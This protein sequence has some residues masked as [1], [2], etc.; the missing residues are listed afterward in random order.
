MRILH[1]ITVSESGGAQSVVISLAN[2]AV[3]AGHEAAVMSDPG[4][5]LWDALDARV[6]RFPCPAFVKPI[7]PKDD[8]FAYLAFRKRRR[9]YRPDIVHLHSSKPGLF[10]RLF[11]G[12]YRRHTVYTVHGFDTIRRG[13]RVFLPL[14][15]LFSRACGAVVA[16]SGHDRDALAAE[17]IV[18]RVSVIQNGVPDCRALAPP[19]GPALAALREARESGRFVALCVARLAPPKRFDLYAEA[20]ARLSDAKAAFFWVGNKAQPEGVVVP[21]NL[22]LLGDV[23][24]A[25]ALMGLCDAVVLLSDY[26]GLPMSV[27]EA[28]AWAK[29]VVASAVGG[30]PEALADG[31]GVILANGPDQA[32]RCAEAIRRLMDDPDEARRIGEAARARYEERYSEAA[33]S[34]A[35]LELYARLRAH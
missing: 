7:S 31:A 25:S 26:E 23:F 13:H 4:G 16:V 17:G 19:D 32:T 30:I 14:E 5:P 20:A 8:L 1:A 33:M 29:P 21:P 10:G 22:C 2:A 35:Y 34:A 3:A 28:M 18:E 12:R 11:A 24:R 9:A 15:R 27:L 6:T